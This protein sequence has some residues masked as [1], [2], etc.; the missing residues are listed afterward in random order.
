MRPDT[1]AAWVTTVALLVQVIAGGIGAEVLRRYARP[2]WRWVPIALV[3]LYLLLVLWFAPANVR[4]LQGDHKTPINP[5]A[6]TDALRYAVQVLGQLAI[7]L[8][9]SLLV[10]Y[11]AQKPQ[12]PSNPGRP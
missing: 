10:L 7:I 4:V 11:R 1:T 5:Y 3:L 6:L 12:G 2:R 9:L 8:G